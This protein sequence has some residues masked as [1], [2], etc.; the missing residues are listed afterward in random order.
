[1]TP[2]YFGSYFTAFYVVLEAQIEVEAEA[3]RAQLSYDAGSG[4]ASQKNMVPNLVS[5]DCWLDDEGS[6]TAS[7]C[8]LR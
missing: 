1:M 5:G 8:L 6:S 2:K 3:Q 4:I 7:G